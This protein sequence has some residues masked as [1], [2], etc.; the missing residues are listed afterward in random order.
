MGRRL[1]L[2]LGRGHGGLGLVELGRPRLLGGWQLKYDVNCRV[3]MNVQLA[4]L[5][6]S[7]VSA[8]KVNIAEVAVA[9]YSV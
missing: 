5:T 4:I 3:E 7:T 1:I 8:M 6:L 9:E 2:W